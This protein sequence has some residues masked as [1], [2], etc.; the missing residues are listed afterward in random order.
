MRDHH[1]LSWYDDYAEEVAT[2]ALQE[3]GVVLNHPELRRIANAIY[4][5]VNSAKVR[6]E[7]SGRKA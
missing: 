2:R 4:G 7:E 1:G 3:F 6:E 5:A